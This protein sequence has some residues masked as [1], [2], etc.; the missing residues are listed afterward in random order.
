MKPSLSPALPLALGLLLFVPSALGAKRKTELTNPDLTQG[1]RIPT[2]APHDWTLGA[3]G[4]RGWVFANKLSTDTSRQIAITAVAPKSPADGIL[5]VGDVILGVGA[6]NF[7]SDARIAFARELTRVEAGDGKLSLLRWRK[8]TTEQVVI[9]LPVLGAYS[10]TAPFNCPK[11]AKILEQGCEALARK[12]A[13]PKYNVSPISRSLNAMALLASGQEKYLP[14]VAKEAKWAAD[15]QADGMATWYYGYVVMFLAEYV[16]ITGDQSVMPGLKR[17]AMEA[18]EGQSAV[19]SWGHKFAT[20]EGRLYGYGMMNAPGV[21]LTTSLVMAR[22][23]GVKD[24]QMDLAIDRSV[25]LLRFYIGKGAVPY[26]DHAPW[27]QTHEDNGKCGMAGVLFNALDD[28][29][30]AEFFARMSLASHGAE[31]EC[32]HTGNFWNITWAMPGVALGGPQ[33]TGAWMKEFGSWY[34]DLARAWDGTFRHQGPAQPEFDHTNGWDATGAYLIAYAMPLKKIGLTGKRPSVIKPFDAQQAAK[35]VADGRGWSNVDRNSAYDA[36]GEEV[37]I[38]RLGSWS[39]IV[40]ERA[41][42]AIQRRGTIALERLVELLG[43]PSIETQLGACQAL[44]FLGEKAAPAAPALIKALDAKDLWLRVKA[45]ESLGKVGQPGMQALPKLLEMI[46]RGPT[47][48]DPRAMEQRFLMDVAFKTM[49]KKS[50]A[51]VDQNAL[52]QAILAGLKNQD[53][54]A[55]GSLGG[56]YEQ[57]PADQLRP[58]LPAIHEAIITPAPS[59]EMFADGIR[60]SGVKLLAKHKIAEGM[61][62]CLD[63]MDIERWNKK[64]RIEAYLGILESYG[65]AAKPLEPRVRQL[66]ADLRAHSEAKSLS[67]HIAKADALADKLAKAGEVPKLVSLKDF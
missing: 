39:P 40:R 30:G 53:G 61:T 7:Q 31:R 32:G 25:K 9:P 2:E 12:I 33:A 55:R 10:A 45:A 28:A 4:A 58:L 41:A 17:M 42:M 1:G 48:A 59:G 6:A 26:G 3:T 44:G 38:E 21:P 67:D 20:P 37:L 64:S 15:F 62:L 54:R 43:S 52:K 24:P 56:I 50:L 16:M 23:A 49:L 14:I 27:Y 46:A 57:L 8:G 18:A 65:A 19:G 11:S 66:A 35:I 34:Y 5:Q 36:L 22:N 63:L 60:I 51:G 29:Q 47:P 13:E